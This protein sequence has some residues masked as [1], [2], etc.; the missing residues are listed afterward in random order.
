MKSFHRL[1]VT[2]LFLAVVLA[3]GHVIWRRSGVPPKRP[4]PPPA[5]EEDVTQVVPPKSHGAGVPKRVLPAFEEWIVSTR[6]TQEFRARIEGEDVD[7]TRATWRVSGPP[8][9]VQHVSVS[10]DA[11]GVTSRFTFRRYGRMPGDY[12]ITCTFS[13]K[14]ATYEPVSWSLTL[15]ACTYYAAYGRK[16]NP[17]ELGAMVFIKGGRFVM[18]APSVP[19]NSHD[20][21]LLGYDKVAKPAHE[22]QIDS[23]HIGKYPVTVIEFC[24]FLNDRGNPDSRYWVMNHAFIRKDDETDVYI[25]KGNRQFYRVAGATWFGAVEYCRWLAQRTGKPYRLP[26]EAEWEYTARGPKGRRYPWGET[27]PIVNGRST[28]P[29]RA[30]EYGVR[31]D[32]TRGTSTVGSFPIASTPEG[33]ADMAGRKREWCHDAYSPDYYGKSPA[34][35]PRGPDV[36]LD[37]L[38][39]FPRVQRHVPA[40]AN[41]DGLWFTT[42]WLG[43]AWTRK[44]AAPL[45]ANASC[46]FRLAMDAEV[47]E[48]PSDTP[49]E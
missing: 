28:N 45:N 48:S 18:G 11:S 8:E 5:N 3:M 30:E 14:A 35:N 4:A 15:D 49:K 29:G 44:H 12:R 9:Q 31:T 46:G 22:V 39:T 16:V 43:P 20:S 1:F 26:T 47:A 37:K 32:G 13:G 42:Y 23:F 24:R 38:D 19:S 34:H 6:I 21:F 2:F 17:D 36:P 27:D 41:W 33:V 7:V 25:P 40:S 10:R